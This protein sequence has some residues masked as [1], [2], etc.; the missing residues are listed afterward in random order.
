MGAPKPCLGYPSRTAAVHALQQQGLSNSEIAARIGIRV[1][2]VSALGGNPERVTRHLT[3][4]QVTEVIELRERGWS[5]LRLAQR[6]NVSPGAIYYHCL[7]YGAVSPLQRSRPVP[8]KAGH[9]V[10]ANG[11]VQRVF[12]VVDDERLLDLAMAN[13]SHSEIARQ[14]GR[15]VTSVRMR[16]MHLALR[17]DIPA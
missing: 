9:R 8:T 2:T 11:R 13:L 3:A 6:F 15:A 14:L 10:C 17:E 5:H 12:T 1:S 16:L 7:K 4:D